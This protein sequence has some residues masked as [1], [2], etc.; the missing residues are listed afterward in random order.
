MATVGMCGEIAG[1][2]LSKIS[3]D[4]ASHHFLGGVAV[5]AAIF[6]ALPLQQKTGV[7]EAL[8]CRVTHL[9]DVE[10]AS[11]FRS[12]HLSTV[13]R[14]ARRLGFV[15][16]ARVLFIRILQNELEERDP[17]YNRA[18]EAIVSLLDLA[19]SDAEV[20]FNLR[21]DQ[22]AFSSACGRD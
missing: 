1:E 20:R 5:T 4:R 2:S 17:D 3:M 9:V 16:T 8:S 6:M 12:N 19:A 21:R 15:L 10:L 22:A 13:A 7:D 18:G 14:I 11:G